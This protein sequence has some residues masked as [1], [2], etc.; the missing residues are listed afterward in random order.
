[1]LL[2]GAI[3]LLLAGRLSRESWACCPKVEATILCASVC[4][5]D[6]GSPYVASVI[7]TYR[8]ENEDFSTLFAEGFA[9]HWEAQLCIDEYRAHPLVARYRLERPQ[10][11]KLEIDYSGIPFLVSDR[12]R[13]PMGLPTLE[14]GLGFG[15]TDGNTVC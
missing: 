5:P 11:S 1:L 3:C 8:V 2:M 15:F 14:T 13:P 4:P 9:T 6:N 7:Y 12:T 10:E